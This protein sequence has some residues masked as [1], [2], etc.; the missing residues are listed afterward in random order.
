VHAVVPL[1]ALLPLL[2]MSFVMRD[3]A[4]ASPAVTGALTGVSA[5]AIGAVVYMLRCNDD[6]PLFLAT[7]YCLAI[8]LVTVVGYLVGTRL[9]RW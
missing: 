8:G 3:S 2:A 9:Y 5:G 1:L 4:P 6:T 7:W